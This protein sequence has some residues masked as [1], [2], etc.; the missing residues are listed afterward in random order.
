MALRRQGSQH[1]L[2]TWPPCPPGG[3]RLWVCYVQPL[4]G[5]R[6]AKW[7]WAE[8]P[9][10]VK[11]SDPGTSMSRAST[12]DM[13]GSVPVWLPQSCG[14]IWRG[15]LWPHDDLL[16]CGQ[17]GAEG[18]AWPSCPVFPKNPQSVLGL[19][20]PC[21]PHLAGPHS[22]PEHSGALGHPLT[23]RWVWTWGRRVGWALQVPLRRTSM[24]GCSC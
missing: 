21:L 1:S 8:V 18:R 12:E 3:H 20:P 16:S 6:G 10:K 9:V 11:L 17:A 15:P 22:K 13:T 2:G 4:D 23:V 5:G 14:A 19:S 7:G 24:L